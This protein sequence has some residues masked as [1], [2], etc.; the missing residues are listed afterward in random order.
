MS[1][2][3]CEICGVSKQ[4]FWN[5]FFCRVLG[6]NCQWQY[7]QVMAMRMESW[8]NRLC[9]KKAE[10]EN[11]IKRIYHAEAPKWLK[12]AILFG[13]RF[14]FFYITAFMT[15][16][17]FVRTVE[18]T[19]SKS[20]FYLRLLCGCCWRLPEVQWLHFAR[21]QFLE[22]HWALRII[23]IPSVVLR[24]FRGIYCPWNGSQCCRRLW[25]YWS[26]CFLARYASQIAGSAVI[27]IAWCSFNGNLQDPLCTVMYHISVTAVKGYCSEI[28]RK[29]R[30]VLNGRH[31]TR[32][33]K[34]N[35]RPASRC[36]RHYGWSDLGSWFR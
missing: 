13:Y 34:K 18:G 35:N 31:T 8:G 26:W 33:I 12:Y 17:P 10:R 1:I 21:R 6:K 36:Y 16:N 3:S 20:P 14:C 29:K 28:I 32:Q 22:L 9:R 19:N 25:L 24:W 7:Q 15:Y 2:I 5:S 27:S 4:L 23:V 11:F 30:M